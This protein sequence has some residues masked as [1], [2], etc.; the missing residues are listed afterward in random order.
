MSAPTA[1]RKFTRRHFLF[2]FWG[3][4]L[5]LYVLKTL[6]PGVMRL[7][8]G[9]FDNSEIAAA[10]RDSVLLAAQR[11]DSLLLRPRTRPRLLDAAGQPV[12]HPIRSVASFE[13][14]FPD[15]N[16]VQLATATRLGVAACKDRTEA[17]ERVKEL[18]YIGDSPFYEVK[19]LSHSIP[20]LV[21]RAA[22]LLDEIGR[23]FLDSLSA[24]GLPFHKLMVT[25]VLRTDADV[26]RLRQHNGNASEQSCHRFGTTFDIA[27]NSYRRVQDSDQ[28][29]QPETWGVHLKSVLAEVLYDLRRRGTC[30][31]KYERR[32]ACFHITA[33]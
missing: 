23:A 6:F 8:L 11:T 30:Y 7:G 5:L 19:P 25:S 3:A 10:P 15:L 26:S 2:A 33:R 31:V 9:A 32:Q 22:T 14:A 28:P 29:R 12:V 18:V 13:E 27:Y 16:D 17:E 20:Y 24:K 1:R 21:P 4:I